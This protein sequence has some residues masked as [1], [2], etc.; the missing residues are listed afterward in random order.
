MAKR[1]NTR[2][3]TKDKNAKDGDALER[4]MQR[5][6]R[7]R[8]NR[9][10][11][12]LITAA[13]E[14]RGPENRFSEDVDSVESLR[15][16]PIGQVIRPEWQPRRYFDPAALKN[17][18]TSVREQG[19]IEPVLVRPVPDK[20]GVF[21]LVAG[22]RRYRAALAVGLETIPVAVRELTDDAALELAIVE[23][24]QREDLNPIEETDSILKLLSTRLNRPQSELV[25]FL[26]RMHNSVNSM[27]DPIDFGANDVRQVEQ[28]F[29][30]IGRL[31]W[32]SFVTS[33]LPILNWPKDVLETVRRGQLAYTKAQ[34]ILR[35]KN[36]KQRYDLLKEAIALELSQAEVR[37]R[38]AEIKAAHKPKI[39]A[40]QNRLQGTVK[41]INRSSI[42]TDPERCDRL[43]SL[44]NTLEELM[45]D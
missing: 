12:T 17:L 16:L 34:L 14:S 13:G 32:Q 36:P 33:R 29:E 40:L 15:E 35:V 39:S 4:L 21:E 43:E 30:S 11:T 10:E 5:K 28:L 2:N 9:R 26:Y 38:I 22:E 20:P 25:A 41:R 45:D 19:I 23:N 7:P 44:L 27:I 24:L 3:N 18:V 31:S 8:V 42:W 1:N 37:R 6:S